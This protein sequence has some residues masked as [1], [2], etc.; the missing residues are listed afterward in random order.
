[1]RCGW[2]SLSRPARTVGRGDESSSKRVGSLAGMPLFD[3]NDTSD[4]QHSRAAHSRSIIDHMQAFPVE[5]PG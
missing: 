3:E 4:W 5:M 2:T 1:M